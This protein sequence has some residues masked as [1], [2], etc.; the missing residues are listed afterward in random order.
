M[1]SHLDEAWVRTPKQRLEDYKELEWYYENLMPGEGPLGLCLAIP[2]VIFN[3]H[4]YSAPWTNFFHMQWYYPELTHPNTSIGPITK[5]RIDERL[6]IVREAIRKV[7]IL[8]DSEK[9]S[10][11]K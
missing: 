3:E 5:E 10:P 6:G 1:T 2:K 8:I 11:N 4:Y 7:E 9:T